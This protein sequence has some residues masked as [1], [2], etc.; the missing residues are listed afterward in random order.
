M[1]SVA[2]FP[3]ILSLVLAGACR[4]DAVPSSG[5]ERLAAVKAAEMSPEQLGILGA[6]IQKEP[7]RADELLAQHG[8]DRESFEQ[9]IRKVSQN[10]E[11][12]KRYAAA[13][14]PQA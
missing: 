14:K 4:R 12:S 1:R 6:Q 2:M 5:S 11:A 3:I 9:A 8:L 7:T 10:S 13:F